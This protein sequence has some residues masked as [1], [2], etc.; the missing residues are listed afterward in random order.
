M[1][2]MQRC[3]HTLTH[4]ASS[5]IFSPDGKTLVSY[6]KNTAKVWDVNTGELKTSFTGL[7]SIAL[8]PDGKTLAGAANG[9]IKLWDLNTGSLKQSL[10]GHS[11]HVIAFSPKGKTLAS[12]NKTSIQL[13]NLSTGELKSTITDKYRKCVFSPDGQILAI[14]LGD[15]FN[16]Q[17]IL[18]WD[19]EMSQR[20]KTLSNVCN[21]GSSIA[22][23]PDGQTLF[24]NCTYTEKYSV[25]SSGGEGSWDIRNHFIKQWDLAT[26]RTLKRISDNHL[27]AISPNGQFLI[28]IEHRS[29]HST[30][31]IKKNIN[32]INIHTGKPVKS[33][34]G[35]AATLSPDG[36]I[37]AI[38]EEGQSLKLLNLPSGTYITTLPGPFSHVTLSED[39]KTLALSYGD[40]IKLWQESTE[41]IVKQFLYGEAHPHLKRLENLLATEQWEDADKETANLIERF[42]SQDLNVIDQLWVHYSHKHYGF[43]VQ[44]SI[45]ESVLR[46]EGERQTKNFRPLDDIEQFK[47]N[48]GWLKIEIHPF[49]FHDNDEYFQTDYIRTK[50]GYYPRKVHQGGNLEILSRLSLAN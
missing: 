37:L 30:E 5:L 20:I 32:I 11:S 31:R 38:S 34:P 9:S 27:G 23:S 21:L 12:Q 15:C 17:G 50:K 41:P 28:G 40:T 26:G 19:V 49:I 13:W 29:V 14:I 46:R 47:F 16:T 48:V 25:S 18:L 45:W 8:S 2:S 6:G 3:I 36:K 44:R 33:F 35:T 1:E 10:T 42:P 4:K 43:S 22:L 7:G 24:S 39:G